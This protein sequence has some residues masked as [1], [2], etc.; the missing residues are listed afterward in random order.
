MV[1]PH[2]GTMLVVMFQKNIKGDWAVCDKEA[3]Q[4]LLQSWKEFRDHCSNVKMIDAHDTSRIYDIF[5]LGGNDGV[6]FNPVSNQW[7]RLKVTV[8]LFFD[9]QPKEASGGGWDRDAWDNWRGWTQG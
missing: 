2:F 7:R 1:V 6:Q 3:Q 9:A 8:E 5:W 4:M